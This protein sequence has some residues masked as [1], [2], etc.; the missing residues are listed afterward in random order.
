MFFGD[1]VFDEHLI[2]NGAAI[3]AVAAVCKNFLR[4]GEKV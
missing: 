2:M 4:D 1:E 3:A